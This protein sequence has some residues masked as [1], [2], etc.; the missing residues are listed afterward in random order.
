MCHLYAL[1]E[2]KV[3]QLRVGFILCIQTTLE[4]RPDVSF[5]VCKYNISPTPQK[6]TLPV[7]LLS[8]LSPT[9]CVLPPKLT[10]K[11][12]LTKERNL[13]FH[14]HCVRKTTKL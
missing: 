14:V 7:S 13:F 3:L 6:T 2:G 8:K 1:T 10:L 5:S 11:S 4:S 12:K 9:S